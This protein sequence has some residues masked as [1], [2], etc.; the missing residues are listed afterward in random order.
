[1]D[2][3]LKVTTRPEILRIVTINMEI[4]PGRRH[5]RVLKRV[6]SIFKSGMFRYGYHLDVNQLDGC[7]NLFK[8]ANYCCT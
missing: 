1:V 8:M 4:Y 7:T 6:S 5:G 2:G 3:H